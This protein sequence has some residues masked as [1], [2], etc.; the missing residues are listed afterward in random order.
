MRVLMMPQMSD[1]WWEARRGLPTAS[2]FKKILTP[3]GRASASQ[4]TYIAELLGDIHCLTPNYFDQHG[5]PSRA[6]QHGTDTEP[7]ARRSFVLDTQ[8]QVQQVGGCVSDCGRFWSSPDGLILNEHN[9]NYPFTGA[10]E[11]KC[12]YRATQVEYLMDGGLPPEYRP[13]CHGHI[14]VTGL[15][16]CHF[17]SYAAGLPALHVVVTRDA[18]TDKLADELERFSEKFEAAK[19]K[20]AGS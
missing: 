5:T 19:R 3:T 11:L 14:I 10:L 15:P 12:P 18:Y 13:Q 9:S 1:L 8:L 6:M 7:E 17:Y 16:I 4:P 2:N 20:I